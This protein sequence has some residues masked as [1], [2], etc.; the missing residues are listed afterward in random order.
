MM[1]RYHEFELDDER[2]RID[3][4]R[5]HGWLTSS[6][7]TP[8]ISAEQVAKAAAGSSLVVGAYRGDEQVG[9][10]RVISDMVRFA[11][12]CDVW[13]DE[14]YRGRGL[15]TAMV[16]FAID[17]PGFATVTRWMLATRDAH[18]VYRR[19]GFRPL[20]EVNPERWMVY[21]PAESS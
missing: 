2:A 19:S 13:V 4:P 18:D 1:T 21:I 12:L 15:A 10:L 5:V 3:V 14:A 7:W 17:H 11:Y 20:L 16:R 8:G 9:Y 6:Y